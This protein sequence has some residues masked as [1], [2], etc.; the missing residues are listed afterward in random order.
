MTARENIIYFGAG[1]SRSQTDVLRLAGANL[2]NYQGSG[3]GL[4]EQSHRSRPSADIIKKAEEHVRDLLA[5]PEGYS[6]IFM[7]GGGTTQFS[8]VAYNLFGF[9]VKKQLMKGLD[10]EEVRR[11]LQRKENPVA[12]DYLITGVWSGKAC[13]EARRLFGDQRVNVAVDARDNNGRYRTIP[14][15]ETWKQTSPDDNVFTYYCDNETV[16]GVEFPAFP[17]ALE[18]R[19]VACDMSSNI[20]TRRV[21]VNKYA[22][23][24]VRLPSPPPW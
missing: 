18:G 5:V 23:I 11:K 14:R 13:K 21:D 16:D 20:L 8:A 19:L 2:L 6:V 1:P 22:V 7:Q 24:F 3:L 17:A 15:E 12:M 9:W 10:K 4:T